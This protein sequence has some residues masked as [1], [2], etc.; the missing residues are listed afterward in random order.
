VD[1]ADSSN[2]YEHVWDDSAAFTITTLT[3]ANPGQITTSAAHGYTTADVVYISGCDATEAN[4]NHYTITVL[5]GTNFTIG[6]DT[7]GWTAA[8]TTGNVNKPDYANDYTF[9]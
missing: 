8:G 9:A 5:D 1:F 3:K 6:V 2:D 7:S 4:G